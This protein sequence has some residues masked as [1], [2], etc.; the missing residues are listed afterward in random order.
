MSN[1][2]IYYLAVSGLQK[3]VRRCLPEV[4]VRSARLAWEQEPYRLFRRL[5]TILYE[6]CPTS[7]TAL[8]H[9]LDNP[10]DSRKWDT[11]ESAVRVMA[12]S[13]TNLMV[14]YLSRLM[15]G[16][17]DISPDFQ[18]FLENSPVA[19]VLEYRKYWEDDLFFDMYQ[20]VEG[21][22]WL[23]DLIKRTKQHDSEKLWAAVPMFWNVRPPLTIPGNVMEAP[24]TPLIVGLPAVG[25]DGHTRP[26]QHAF[27]VMWSH[28]PRGWA[29]KDDGAMAYWVEGSLRNSHQIWFPG[30]RE[31]Y[32]LS[33]GGKG[34]DHRVG[35]HADLFREQLADLTQCRD[36]VM[37]THY[38]SEYQIL[39]NTAV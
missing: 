25:F 11:I 30:L 4:A 20:D 28:R 39:A 10:P 31:A 26:G 37:R 29:F 9:F 35:P 36:W 33:Q 38:A 14:A 22:D 34:L 3:A 1:L 24:E 2:N 16:K 18:R 12:E 7:E 5:H 19:R 32:S 8:R 23:F 15:I 6:D 17:D 13:H 27:R 21:L